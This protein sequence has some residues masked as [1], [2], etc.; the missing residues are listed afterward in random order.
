MNTS[1]LYQAFGIQ[2]QE[3]IKTKY[4]HCKVCVKVKTKESKLQ[5]SNCKGWNFIKAGVKD[6]LFRTIPISGKPV[7]ILAEIQRIECKD[8]GMTRLEHIHYAESKKTYTHS[9]RRYASR[10]IKNWHHT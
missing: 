6:R 9:F 10:I 1:L 7:F 5:C 2:H 4:L 3:V 8:S